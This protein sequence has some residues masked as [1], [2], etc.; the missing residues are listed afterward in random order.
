LG[1]MVARYA[2]AFGMHVQVWG[3][4]RARSEA[5]AT[6]LSAC[7]SRE[8]F[9]S[10]SDVITVHLRLADSTR[11]SITLS[12]L[13]LMKSDAVFVNT[14]RAEL[15]ESNALET[16]LR[17]GHPGY[18]A[19]DVYESEPIYGTDHPLLQLPNLLCTPHLGYVA[20]QS[21]EA[22]FQSA[23]QNVLQ[24]FAGDVSKVLNPDYRLAE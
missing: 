5:L 15:L 1:K 20:Q 23:F 11:A 8:D 7:S 19:I 13:A 2:R 24:F 9:F 18:A 17:Q 16:A 14:S 12:D 21:Y 10:S 3:S 4:E 6:G 22:Y